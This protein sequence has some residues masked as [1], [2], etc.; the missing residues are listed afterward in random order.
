MATLFQGTILQSDIKDN[1]RP[2]R[3]YT[4]TYIALPNDWEYSHCLSANYVKNST[5]CHLNI[6]ITSID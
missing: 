3:Q 1:I 6:F 5:F 4:C 2:I